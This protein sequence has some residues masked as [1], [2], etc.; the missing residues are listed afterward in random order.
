MTQL[1]PLIQL[2]Q[3]Q[4][5]RRVLLKIAKELNRINAIPT[6]TTTSDLVKV[7]DAVNKITGKI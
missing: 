5:T 3:D 2:I 1:E 4:N 7:R 6:V